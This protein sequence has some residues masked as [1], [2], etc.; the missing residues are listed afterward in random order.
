MSGFSAGR[1]AEPDRDPGLKVVSFDPFNA[2]TPL[3]TQAGIVTP[4]S[5]HYVRNHFGIPSHPG[6]LTIEGRVRRSLS[7]A[8]AD[9]LSRP[10]TTLLV[11][12][13]CAGNG[14][15][16]LNPPAPGEQWALGAVGTAEWAG[17]PLSQ[18]LD[19]AQLTADAVEIAFAGADRGMP[20]AVGHEIGFERSMPPEAARTALIALSMNGLP[21]PPDHGAPIRLIV[22]GS[23]GMASVKWL[24]RV[25]ALAVPF[26]GFFQADRYVI[27][28]RP[29]GPIAPRAVIVSPAEN[30]RLSRGRQLVRGY[31]WSGAAP[32]DEVEVSLD[33]GATWESAALGPAAA[34]AAWQGWQLEWHPD[35]VGPAVLLA[36]AIDAAGERQ[37][38]H[39]VR[40]ELG[41]RN[42]AAQPVTVEVV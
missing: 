4:N 2:E 13:E 34:P 18:L 12:L 42:N 40:N 38:V 39:Q 22:P 14:R 9:L 36:R 10:Q 6:R 21:L 32:I 15:R 24:T 20:A 23:Y 30:D 31:A 37:P 11:T 41:Y 28:G 27:D 17:V 33:G 25:I 19:E 35:R 16:F 8:V 7:L 29:L 5:R 3:A 1:Q 26:R